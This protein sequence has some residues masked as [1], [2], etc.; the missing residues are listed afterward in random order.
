LDTVVVFPSLDSEHHDDGRLAPV[1]LHLLLSPQHLV[2]FL[3]EDLDD[4]V[5]ARQSSERFLL[6]G[7]PLHTLRHGQDE[8]DV[9]IGLDERSLQVSYELLD[10]RFIDHRSPQ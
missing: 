6:E 9:H 3:V 10:G 4:L 2:E 8:L 5:L 1:E 7:P